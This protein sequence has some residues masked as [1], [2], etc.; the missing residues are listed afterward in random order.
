MKKGM[1]RFIAGGFIG[2]A[3]G[4]LFAL[5]VSIFI[6]D[7]DFYLVI[8]AI[9]ERFGTQL[10]AAIVQTILTALLGG[11]YSV[12]SL[13]YENEDSSIVKQTITHFLV[14]MPAYLFVSFAMGWIG[15][16]F[17]QILIYTLIYL[18]IYIVIWIVSYIIWKVKINKLNQSINR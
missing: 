15:K 13:I 17:I 5:A 6:N 14:T 10:N 18:A 12:A 4:Y 2:I 1:F 11:V 9:I 16:E 7:G 8:P 3:I